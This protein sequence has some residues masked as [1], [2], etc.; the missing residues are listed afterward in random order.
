MSPPRADALAVA[1]AA[2]CASRGGARDAGARLAAFE[3]AHRAVAGGASPFAAEIER[4]SAAVRDDLRVDEFAARL[5]CA[6][7][8]SGYAL[9]TVPVALFAW[10]RHGDDFRAV[11][12]H[13]VRCGGDTDST[14][15]IAG[16]IAGA[17][18]G[19]RAIPPSWLAGIV[20]WP[21]GVAWMRARC[22]E[23]AADAPARSGR[24]AAEFAWW[25]W[26]LARNL[27]ALA[28]LLVALVRR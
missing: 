8:V 14:A 5:G 19:E 9:H 20:E 13:V 27:A 23:L 11:V 15:A 25:P 22:D 6:R 3:Q 16:A 18:L 2:G 7:G 26:S 21:R 4:L 17:G 12:T 24:L 10:M 1:I 28:V